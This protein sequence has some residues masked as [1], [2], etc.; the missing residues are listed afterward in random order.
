MSGDAVKAYVYLLCEAWLQEPRATL[1]NDDAE[2]ASIARLSIE[3]WMNIKT[4][5]IRSFKIGECEEHLGRLYNELQLE[6]S[7]KFEKNQRLNNKNAR[8]TR[9]KR[10]TNAKRSR[11]IANANAIVSSEL[12]VSELNEKQLRK[13]KLEQVPPTMEDLT[14]YC[15]ERYGQGHPKVSAKAFFDHYESNGWLVGKSKMKSWHASVRTWEHNAGEYARAPAKPSS[16]SVT[17]EQ[18]NIPK[19]W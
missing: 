8:R 9:N 15:A 2:L 11:D 7:R 4:S 19:E 1:P 5:V 3:E 6:V 18:L 10:D 12:L 14:A 17:P 16:L 13:S